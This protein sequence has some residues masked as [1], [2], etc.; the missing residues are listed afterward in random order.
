MAKIARLYRSLPESVKSP[1]R[2]ALKSYPLIRWYYA[3]N[4][5]LHTKGWMKSEEIGVPVDQEGRPLPWYT[6][7]AID[8]IEP[9]IQDDFRVFEFGCGNSSL[10]YSKRVDEVVAVEDSKKWSVE[11]TNRSPANVT[12]IHRSDHDVYS[13]E[14]TN[15]GSFDIVVI[16]GS[17]RRECVEPTLQAISNEGIVILDD[18]ERWNDDDWNSLRE[19][20][21]RSLPFVGPKAQR[22]TESCTAILYRD[23]NCLQI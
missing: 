17:V 5:Y 3:Q 14:V 16:D 12:V 4:S 22:L 8:F 18:F 10:W 11:M 1:I 23:Q 20:G 9:R 13:T 6:Y 7:P 19:T 21:F 2:S 15:H